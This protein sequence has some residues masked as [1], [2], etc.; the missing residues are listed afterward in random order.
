M[1]CVYHETVP[2]FGSKEHLDKVCELCHKVQICSLVVIHLLPLKQSITQTL[3]K[4]L[5]FKCTDEA[6]TAVG[7]SMVQLS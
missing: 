2:H 6:F 4:Y 7:D 3:L 1:L 5:N